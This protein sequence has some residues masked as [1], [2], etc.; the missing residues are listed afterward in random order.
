M[1]TLDIRKM[2]YSPKLEGS[3]N[4]DMPPRTQDSGWATL[5]GDQRR[6]GGSGWWRDPKSHSFQTL[7][8][9][10]PFAWN[11]CVATG[12]TKSMWFTSW[13]CGGFVSLVPYISSKK[14]KKKRTLHVP[15][16]GMLGK[17]ENSRTMF[18][19]VGA[20]TYFLA[21]KSKD[22]VSLNCDQANFYPHHPKELYLPHDPN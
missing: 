11:A 8:L 1:Q 21:R 16:F 4:T 3:V 5:K 15:K 22:R 19:F 20:C 17:R 12:P 14:K 9:I 18:Y 2:T 7:Y 6:A 10:H 13:S